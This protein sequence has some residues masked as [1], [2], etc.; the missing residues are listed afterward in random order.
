VNGTNVTI[1][2]GVQGRV[3]LGPSG[4]PGHVTIPLRYALVSESLTETKPLWS[5][6]YMI[7]VDIPPQTPS[8]SFTNIS[9]DLTVP[10]PPAAELSNWVIYIGFDPNGA[11]QQPKGKPARAA[12]PRQV[13]VE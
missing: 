4:E 1:K 3:I 11:L 13:K 10:I 9:D 12:K 5:K 7:P 8:V 6:L 2:I